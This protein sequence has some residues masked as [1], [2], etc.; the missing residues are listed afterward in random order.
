MELFVPSRKAD[1]VVRKMMRPEVRCSTFPT[2]ASAGIGMTLGQLHSRKCKLI[3][4]DGKHISGCLGMVGQAQ[5]GGGEIAEGHKETLGGN[6][7]VLYLDGGASIMDV[8][9]THTS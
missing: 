7:Y 8:L 4:G 9:H 5:V 2:G 1:S 3:Q 6:R